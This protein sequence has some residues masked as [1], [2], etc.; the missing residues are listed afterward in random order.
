MSIPIRVSST[1]FGSQ[2]KVNFA[3]ESET[4]QQNIWTQYDK[5][6]GDNLT[7]VFAVMIV[8]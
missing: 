1:I 7:H 6:Y 5:Q 3:M 2:Q 8:E 4:V